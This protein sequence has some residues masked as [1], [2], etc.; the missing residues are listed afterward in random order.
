MTMFVRIN[1]KRESIIN[2]GRIFFIYERESTS[3][4]EGFLFWATPEEGRCPCSFLPCFS[5]FGSFEKIV[6]RKLIDNDD[7]IFDP[8]LETIL[9]IFGQLSEGNSCHQ[10]STLGKIPMKS[11]SPFFVQ[12]YLRPLFFVFCHGFW[13][14]EIAIS[15]RNFASRSR[16]ASSISHVNVHYHEYFTDDIV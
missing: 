10:L 2:W 15:A 13:G 4:R 9:R 6:L 11:P 3:C 16:T 12:I 7:K 8:S 14:H 1:I 5:F